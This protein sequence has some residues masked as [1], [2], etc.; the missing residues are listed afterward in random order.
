MAILDIDSLC[1]RKT[2][3]R[4]Q[5]LK[6]RTPVIMDMRIVEIDDR[7]GV[8]DVFL[9]RQLK[10]NDTVRA[11]VRP[12]CCQEPVRRRNM[13]KHLPAQQNIELAA[14]KTRRREHG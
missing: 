10:K 5:T 8:L 2:R 9:A 1:N 12:D 6:F 3:T 13:L 4:E 11:H 14:G 7:K